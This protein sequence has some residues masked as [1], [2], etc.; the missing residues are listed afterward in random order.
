MF[1]SLPLPSSAY[2]LPH[3]PSKLLARPDMNT[4]EKRRLLRLPTLARLRRLRE[5]I[6]ECSRVPENGFVCLRPRPRASHL[7]RVRACGR[8]NPRPDHDAALQPEFTL[9]AR[10]VATFERKLSAGCKSAVTRQMPVGTERQVCRNPQGQG[11][12]YCEPYSRTCRQLQSLLERQIRLS[13]A[14][15]LSTPWQALKDRGRAK[16]PSLRRTSP[17]CRSTERR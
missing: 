1:V 17:D 11:F 14:A 10:K 13:N 12:R 9:E 15:P 16:L 4:V 5:H 2:R 8:F 6:I 3:L 7:R